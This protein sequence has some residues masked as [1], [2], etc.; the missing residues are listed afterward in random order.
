MTVSFSIMT[1][2]KSSTDTL[3]LPP[4]YHMHTPL[5]KHATGTPDAYR[6]AASTRKI[7]E[8]G[9]TDHAPD[10]S[11]YD[12]RHRMSITQ[13]PSYLLMIRSLQDGSQPKTLLGI[14]A[15]YYPGAEPFL[16]DWLPRQPFDLILGSVHY[17]NDWAFDNPDTLYVW[18]SVDVKGVWRQYFSLIRSL[19]ELGVADVLSHFDLPKKFGH[20]ISDCDVREIVS[21]LLDNI[22]KA[23]MAIE[24]NT[25]GWRRK[26][27][28]AY[29]SPLIL[30]LMKERNIPIT[31]GSD[32]H[33]PAEVGFAF[34]K[35][36][37]LAREAGYTEFRRY[38]ARQPFNTPIP[39]SPGN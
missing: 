27:A 22:A 38:C 31:F 19:V 24:I 21:P 15:D 17:I 20:R 14:E 5:C 7:E 25:S 11:G 3:T 37:V 1:N 26:V 8:I 12:L 13:Y 18:D 39:P 32:A 16:K 35:A 9:F 2:T 6:S 36:V 23:G 30:G 34:D 4:D 10:P 33:T 29:P 28:E